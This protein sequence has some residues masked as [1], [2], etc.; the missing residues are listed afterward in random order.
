MSDLLNELEKDLSTA[1]T[2]VMEPMNMDISNNKSNIFVNPAGVPNDLSMYGILLSSERLDNGC[3]K[4]EDDKVEPSLNVVLE[5]VD[6]HDLVHD[7]KE[8]IEMETNE[9]RYVFLF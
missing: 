2:M 6:I 1:E 7:S 4:G 8:I 3:D 5:N 9:K